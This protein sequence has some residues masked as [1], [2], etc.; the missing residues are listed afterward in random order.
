MQEDEPANYNAIWVFTPGLKMR[1]P[2]YFRVYQEFVIDPNQCDALGHIPQI[3]DA[4]NVLFTAKDPP[5]GYGQEVYTYNPKDDSD[6]K[7]E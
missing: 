4:E 3:K 2:N 6:R 1:D 7:H 5:G